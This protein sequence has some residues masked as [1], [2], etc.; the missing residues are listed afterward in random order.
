VSKESAQRYA[1]DSL[2][3][4]SVPMTAFTEEARE[5]VVLSRAH[6]RELGQDRVGTEHLLLGLNGSARRAKPRD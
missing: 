5:A 2:T 3:A 1:V 4:K 6:A